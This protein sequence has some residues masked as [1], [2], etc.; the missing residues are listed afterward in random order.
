M[1]TR[2]MWLSA[3][4]GNT[5]MVA[6]GSVA[7]VCEAF[8]SQVHAAGVEAEVDWGEAQVAMAG[9]CDAGST[10]FTCARVT[11]ARRS[12]WR[13]RTA[14]SRRS[15]RL[16]SQAFDWF[17][18]VFGLLRYDNLALAVKQVLRGRRRVRVRPVHR[19][20]LALSL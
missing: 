15:W 12:R 17:G 8:V 6:G 18:G 13:S 1:S 20:A 16:M 3:R 19:V 9:V 7:K 5:F 10:C 14:L 11:P 2:L 4:S